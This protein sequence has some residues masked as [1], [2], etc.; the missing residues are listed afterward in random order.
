MW[1]YWYHHCIYYSL[2][3]VGTSLQSLLILKLKNLLDWRGFKK[4]R[5]LITNG[6]GQ[7]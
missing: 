6:Y 4:Q 5:M 7:I 1:M 2:R 3:A